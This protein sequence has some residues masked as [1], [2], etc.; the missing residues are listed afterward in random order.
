MEDLFLAI[1]SGAAELLI[2]VVLQIIGEALIA[3][4]VRSIRNLVEESKAVSPILAA[5]GYL[6]LGAACGVGSVLLF[7][8]ALVHPSKFRGISLVISPVITGL[9]M[10]LT[11]LMRRR[12]GKDAIRIESFGYGFTFALGVAVIRFLS[13]K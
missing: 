11:G 2:E 8:H 10:S 13:A 9:I 6:L 12:R 4:I 3:L 7:P 1:L 5:L